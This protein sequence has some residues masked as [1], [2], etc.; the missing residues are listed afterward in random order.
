MWESRRDFQREWEGWEA[1]SLAFHAFHSLSFPRPD[2][3]FQRGSSQH[4]LPPEPQGGDIELPDLD[5][6]EEDLVERLGD[7]LQAEFL[8]P[9]YFADEIGRAHV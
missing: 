3:R 4:R 6:A 9:E 5:L 8:E 2:A 1:G 7:L